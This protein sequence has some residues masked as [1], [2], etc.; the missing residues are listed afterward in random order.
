MSVLSVVLLVVGLVLL[1]AGAEFLVRGAARLA[2]LAGVS[3]LVIGLTVVSYGTSAPEF[4]VS[5]KSGLS[6]QS[7]IALGNV[8][9]SNL[10]NVLFIL[11][12]CALILPLRVDSQLVR[13]DVPIM[14]GVSIVMWLMS[15]DGLLGRLDGFLLFSGAITYT[16]F[17]VVKSRKESLAVKQ[18]FDQEFAPPPDR[19]A[20]TILWNLALLIFGLV[21]LVG[22]ARMFVN[23]AVTIAEAMGVSQVVI[24]LT[25]VAVGTSLPEVAT[26]IVATL[27][28]ERDIAIGNVV[29]S[30]IFNIL[31]VLGAASMAT[32]IRVTP[33]VL[34]VDIPVMVGVALI[35]LP[36]FFTG[37]IILRWEGAMF[38]LLYAFYTT[39]LILHSVNSPFLGR[40]SAAVLY[41]IVPAVVLALVITT[42]WEFKHKSVAAAPAKTR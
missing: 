14:I 10:F 35:C 41:G 37:L 12:A 32:P 13:L 25:I 31:C 15:L 5:I 4:A 36:I 1:T 38:M 33:E 40:F 9:G 3:S 30:N 16:V 28:G 39:Y 26:S 23:G 24:G 22:G 2:A 27:R 18:E 20:K 8:V 17:T 11:G 34:A 19:G 6:G 7:D 29:G 42:V 21:L